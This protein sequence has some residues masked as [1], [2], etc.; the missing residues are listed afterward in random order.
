MW[1]MDSLLGRDEFQNRGAIHTHG[2]V[3]VEKSI[4]ELN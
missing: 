2:V 3:W 1:K 4:D